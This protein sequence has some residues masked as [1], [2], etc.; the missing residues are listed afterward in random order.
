V[1]R[2]IVCGVAGARNDCSTLRVAAGVAE[3][4]GG[5][6][7]IVLV[8]DERP[9]GDARESVREGRRTIACLARRCAVVD[10]AVHWVEVGDPVKELT[11]VSDD[12]DAELLV[13]GGT[14]ASML[15]TLLKAGVAPRLS[16]RTRRPVAIVPPAAGDED[17]R[18]LM[19]AAVRST[20][21]GARRLARLRRTLAVRMSGHSRRPVVLSG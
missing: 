6:L 12:L 4:M 1:T 10:D 14:R 17:V 2:W 19:D 11:R 21:S 7:A 13:V 18:A 16:G 15:A 8:V 20:P 3:R 5:R 9:A